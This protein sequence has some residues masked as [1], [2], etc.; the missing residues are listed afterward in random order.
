[1]EQDA[2][3]GSGAM[4]M[5]AP[6]ERI[7]TLE[8]ENWELKRLIQE[9]EAKTTLQEN[10]IKEVVDRCSVIEAATMEMVRQAR[11]QEVF[12]GSVRASID[13]LV[14]QVKNDQNNFEMVMRVL[15]AHETHIVKNWSAASEL[16]HFI[17][18][19]AQENEK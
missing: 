8:R 11:Q 17:N 6:V 1:M 13:V 15:Q 4:Q 19:V 16:A 14:T 12:N 3:E 18:T 5:M 2:T 7:T 10:A 9:M